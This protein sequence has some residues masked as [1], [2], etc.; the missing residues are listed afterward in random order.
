MADQYKVVYDLSN[1]AIFND[2]ERPLPQFQGH[3]IFDAE[4]LR[5]GMTYRHSFNEILGTYTRATEHSF[6]MTF[7]DL[8]WLSK[9]FS[10]MKRRAVSLR[11]LSFLFHEY[12]SLLPC[13]VLSR[14]IH[15]E[16]ENAAL[17]E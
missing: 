12:P 6:W 7:C 1:G 15:P 3:A 8:E 2:F 13:Q 14:P 16:N 5:N 4:Y 11:Q 9:I 10:D 17:R